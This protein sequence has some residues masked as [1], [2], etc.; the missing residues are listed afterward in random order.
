MFN[1]L[2]DR[3]LVWI[4]QRSL[5]KFFKQ[6]G[7]KDF[8]L[9]FVIGIGLSVAI[10]SCTPSNSA[11]NSADAVK[12]PQQ[13]SQKSELK[14][15][16]MANQK[17]MALLNILKAQGSLEKRLQPQ[18]ISVTWN[19]FSSTAPLL[20][21]MGVGSVV[22]GGGGGT[23]SVFAQAGDKPFVRVA[24]STSSTRS[25][26]I[27]VLEK[28]PIK[29]LADL[30]GKK[31]GF[32]KGA[33][34]QYMIVKA[35]EKVGLKYSDIQPVFLPP[36]DALPAFERGDFD[37][38]VIWDPYTAEA[39][40]K[41]KTRL[42]AD[43]TTV[44]GDKAPTESPA[45]YYASPDFVRDHPEIVKIILEELQKAGDWARNNNKDSAK[46]LSELYKVDL[47]TMEIVEE[48][49]GERKVLPI[50]NEVLSGLQHMA[51]TFTELKVIPKKIDVKDK[52]Y[53]WITDQKSSSSK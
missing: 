18:G 37:A 25:S 6:P 51:D 23:G 36:A 38:W 17:G 7:I 2:V 9:L 30:K 35:L 15:L 39:E 33:S 32:A 48:R 52:N 49:G 47:K 13:V 16:K 8:A 11:T 14:V 3:L 10:A 5:L 4:Y 50:N 41:L 12:A 29:T 46:L 21:G 19:E 28:S 20:E 34:S 1:Q 45:F 31:V 44:F 43:N 40:R 22:F 24:A 42:L 27:L 53:N 26:A